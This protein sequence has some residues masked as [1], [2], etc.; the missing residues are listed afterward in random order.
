M[1]RGSQDSEIEVIGTATEP[2]ARLVK[3]HGAAAWELL[4]VAPE[5]HKLH[6]AFADFFSASGTAQQAQKLDQLGRQDIR[7]H[8]IFPP[9]H[10]EALSCGPL[11]SGIC[12]QAFTNPF[13]WATIGQDLRD[14]VKEQQRNWIVATNRYVDSAHE[15]EGRPQIPG[16]H[17]KFSSDESQYCA[18]MYLRDY[19][20]TELG[21]HAHSSFATGIRSSNRRALIARDWGGAAALIA[22]HASKE[23]KAAVV[24]LPSMDHY[25]TIIYQLVPNEQHKQQQD[26]QHPRTDSD[27]SAYDSDPFGLMELLQAPRGPTGASRSPIGSQ[28]TG[29]HCAQDQWN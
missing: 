28:T 11:S 21:K 22:E 17:W 2:Y 10:Q 26:Y 25:A 19:M 1:D 6:I 15:A 9:P 5:N 20:L 8:R 24:F 16:F 23:Q 27:V 3:L 14:L 13:D 29:T 12:I 7:V 4:P 18:D